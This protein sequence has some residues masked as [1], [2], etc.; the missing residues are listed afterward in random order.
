[1]LYD[2]R[3]ERRVVVAQPHKTW[4][5]VLIEAAAVIELRGLHRGDLLGCD[6]SVCTMGAI[7]ELTALDACTGRRAERKLRRFL[8]VKSIPVWNDDRYRTKSEV[9]TALRV[10]AAL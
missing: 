9:V 8:K 4:R 10:C 6:G 5:A 7:S 1:M 2:P 3:W